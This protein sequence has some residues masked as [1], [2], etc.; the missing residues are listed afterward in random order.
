MSHFVKTVLPSSFN[1]GSG[2]PLASL[3][4]VH[5][6]G[7]DSDWMRKS[8]AAGVFKD[9]D[10][11]PEKGSAYVHLIAMGD[12]EHYGANRN[13]DR[14][15]KESHYIDIPHPKHGTPN[16]V[17]INKGNKETYDTFEKYAHVYLN[18]VNK[19]PKKAEGDVVKAAH[20]D[21]MARV[22][23]IIKVPEDKWHDDLEKL[24]SG[25]DVA[26]SMSCTVPY[27]V[28]SYCGNKAANRSKY[29]EH[30][31]YNMGSITKEGS[32]ICVVNDHMRY[33]DISK[34]VVPADRI[35]FGL[36]KAASTGIVSGSE[37]AEQLNIVAPEDIMATPATIDKLAMIRKLSEIEKEIEAT[38]EGDSPI[39]SCAQSFDKDVFSKDVQDDDMRTLTGVSRADIPSVLG[40]LADAKITLSLQDFFKLVMGNKF[41][42][43]A[44]HMDSAQNMLPGIFSRMGDGP[45]KMTSGMG[46]MELGEGLVPRKV[47]DII[48]ELI[49]SSSMDSEPTQRRMTVKILRGGSPAKIIKASNHDILMGTADLVAERLAAVYAMYKVSYCQ[50]VGNNEDIWT[51]AV[52]HNYC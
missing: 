47:R 30:A 23:L 27:D 32:E 49:P 25:G 50:R 10:I 14:F 21:D 44:P 52:L 43:L 15:D 11:V 37:L 18:H 4:D 31:K 3:V 33:F 16:R 5:S 1:Y 17:L 36:L 26:F 8:A 7:V 9:A 22:E 28:C 39:N 38:A 35:A 20:N 24:A 6:H 40:S 45:C 13:A 42:A 2:M 12:G 46:E 34:V 41:E 19:D 48:Q 29:C 51:K